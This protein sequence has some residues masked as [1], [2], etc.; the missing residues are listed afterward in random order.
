MLQSAINSEISTYTA[1]FLIQWRTASTSVI[2]RQKQGF[3]VGVGLIGTTQCQV[4][5]IADGL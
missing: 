2:G 1:A 3:P 4:I 5:E